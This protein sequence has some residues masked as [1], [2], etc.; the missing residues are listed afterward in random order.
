MLQRGG[1]DV[2]L[3]R[4]AG[5]AHRVGGAVELAGAV[6]AP[7]DH[8]AHRAVDVHEHRGGLA[9]HGIP[10]RIAAANSRPPRSAAFCMLVSSAVRTT[11]T[12]SVIDF[13]KVSTSFFI[14][15]KAQS[16]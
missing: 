4:R 13:G 15:S 1:I 5:L 12:R 3:E 14:S 8:G 11:K 7:A 9:W 2:G 16:R 6:V 10:G